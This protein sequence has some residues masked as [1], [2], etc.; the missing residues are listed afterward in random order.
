[1]TDANTPFN[2]ESPDTAA[3][4]LLFKYSLPHTLKT[5]YCPEIRETPQD[6]ERQKDF[7]GMSQILAGSVTE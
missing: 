5:Y 7:T 2:K 6:N 4:K 1:M 3:C